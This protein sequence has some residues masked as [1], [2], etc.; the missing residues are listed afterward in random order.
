MAMLAYLGH[1]VGWLGPQYT[2]TYYDTSIRRSLEA[3]KQGEG[4]IVE[5]A[6]AQYV[7][8][9]DK[10]AARLLADLQPKQPAAQ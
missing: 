8:Q 5:N 1:Y 3:L 4:A 10:N 7:R 9:G 2:I 6:F